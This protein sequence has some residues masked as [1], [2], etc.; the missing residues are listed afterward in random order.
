MT[1]ELIEY[2]FMTDKNLTQNITSFS[3]KPF[4]TRKESEKNVKYD[5]DKSLEDALR[6]KL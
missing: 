3:R 4:L 6:R 5:E 1:A 2:W